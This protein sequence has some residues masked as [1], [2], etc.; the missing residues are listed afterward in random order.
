MM[1]QYKKRGEN[2]GGV[3]TNFS[4]SAR[5]TRLISPPPRKILRAKQATCGIDCT[6]PPEETHGAAFV[7]RDI[8]RALP[9]H[10]HMS[11]WFAPVSDI[12][13]AKKKVAF[14]FSPKVLK[15]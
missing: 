8:F 6:E 2:Q 4:L 11:P 9:C 3:S 13:K 12:L 1:I 10:H 15:G 14:P 5:K 7:A